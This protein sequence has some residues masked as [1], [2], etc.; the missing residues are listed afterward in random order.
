MAHKTIQKYVIL[1]IPMFSDKISAIMWIAP[2]PNSLSGSLK[3]F[4]FS[5]LT[6]SELSPNR[7]SAVQ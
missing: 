5:I 4:H 7:V 3:D 2:L 6:G 1:H